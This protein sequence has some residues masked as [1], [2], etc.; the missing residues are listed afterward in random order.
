[1]MKSGSPINIGREDRDRLGIESLVIIWE[2]L[3]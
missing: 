3:R 2:G 1:M